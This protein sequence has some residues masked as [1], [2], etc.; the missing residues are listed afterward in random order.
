[1]KR[2]HQ[3]SP[4]KLV[5]L[6]T[7]IPFFAR[8]TNTELAQ[9]TEFAQIFIAEPGEPVIERGARDTCF[10]VMLSGHAEVRLDKDIAP[11]AELSPGDIFGEIGFVLNTPRTSW[12]MAQNMCALMRIDQMLMNNLDF[13]SRDKI[14][15]Q[16]IVKLAKTIE[17][18]NDMT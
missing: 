8:F 7:K 2:T 4:A 12:V 17:N 1:M 6:M 9:V 15:D 3:L 11:V 14:K 18:L 10:Y 13:S 16:I 5:S